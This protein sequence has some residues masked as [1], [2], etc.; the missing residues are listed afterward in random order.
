MEVADF[1]GTR[2]VTAH[3]E[4]VPMSSKVTNSVELL[5]K[6]PTEEANGRLLA[7]LI[8]E[9]MTLRQELKS[10]VLRDATPRG[11]VEP[12]AEATHECPTTMSSPR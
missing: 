8:G 1:T 2:A 3:A 10:L 6:L 7:R 4:R 5:L 11:A 12:P 9:T